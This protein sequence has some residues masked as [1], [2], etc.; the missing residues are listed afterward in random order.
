MSVVAIAVRV[1]AALS[2]VFSANSM[3]DFKPLRCYV[4]GIVIVSGEPPEV[5]ILNAP[6]VEFDVES[7]TI[8]STLLPHLEGKDVVAI[9]TKSPKWD[10]GDAGLYFNAGAF[11]FFNLYESYDK[12]VLENNY[13]NNP[14]GNY[15][16]R[17]AF[18]AVINR[19]SGVIEF[20]NYDGKSNGSGECRAITRKF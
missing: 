3:A 14:Y 5:E 11:S 9:R 2:L 18:K 17:S 13:S 16:S 4:D 10:D 15:I 7:V 19:E 20:F 1:S 6:R 12:Y 8:D